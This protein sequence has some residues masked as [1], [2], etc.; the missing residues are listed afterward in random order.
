M[1]QFFHIYTIPTSFNF[2]VVERKKTHWQLNLHQYT[3]TCILMEVPSSLCTFLTVLTYTS[4]TVPLR[5]GIVDPEA[6]RLLL[7][8]DP[9]LHLPELILSMWSAPLIPTPY[10]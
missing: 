4:R 9:A 3:V 1:R 10:G 2:T 8:Q 5:S 7:R 6:L